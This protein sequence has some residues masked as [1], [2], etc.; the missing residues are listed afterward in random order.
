MLKLSLAWLLSEIHK[1]FQSCDSLSCSSG[2]RQSFSPLPP[3]PI[4]SQSRA[5]SGA[6]TSGPASNIQTQA[7]A[8]ALSQPNRCLPPIPNPSSQRATP[9]PP[10]PLNAFGQ[11]FTYSTLG[12]CSLANLHQLKRSSAICSRSPEPELGFVATQSKPVPSVVAADCRR[13]FASERSHSMFDPPSF[14]Q[15]RQRMLKQQSTT[16]VSFAC[17]LTP[18]RR[19]RMT[20]S[21]QQMGSTA[22]SCASR[23]LSDPSSQDEEEVEEEGDDE[24][25]EREEEEEGHSDSFELSGR[26]NF[27]V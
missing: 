6:R 22:G 27:Q 5:S 16:V 12:S 2:Q 24:G 15:R 11:P 23:M 4:R 3:L 26:N 21:Q 9:T 13:S 25:E 1:S 20:T 10:P 18:D 19:Q 14:Q 17:S 8:S 7:T